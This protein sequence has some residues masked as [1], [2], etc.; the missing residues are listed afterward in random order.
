MAAALSLSPDDIDGS[1]PVQ[2]V[3][4]GIVVNCVPLVDLAALE[5]AQMNPETFA[6]LRQQGN[7]NYA[8]KFVL[9]AKAKLA[10]INF[11]AS[12]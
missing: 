11:R 8:G 3:S 10:A 4:V 1:S 2:Q 12:I 5:R 7:R 9:K 6:P